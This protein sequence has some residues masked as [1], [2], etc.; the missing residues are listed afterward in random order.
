MLA[1]ALNRRRLGKCMSANLFSQ[2]LNAYIALCLTL[3]I[4]LSLLMHFLCAE[5][6]S[7]ALSSGIWLFYILVSV[8]CLQDV[9]NCFYWSLLI[10][11]R[12][13]E[14]SRVLWTY[15]DPCIYRTTYS[16][17][18]PCLYFHNLRSKTVFRS[19]T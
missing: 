2:D 18:R 5:C 9:S 13:T 6:S 3:C 17:F 14:C 8:W 12:P 7:L 1:W 4:S 11:K 15:F 10:I 19:R 16:I